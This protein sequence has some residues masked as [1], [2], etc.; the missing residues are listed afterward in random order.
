VSNLLR[1]GQA[2]VNDSRSTTVSPVAS[3]QMR[4][5]GM[6][7]EQPDSSSQ[8]AAVRLLQL[9]GESVEMLHS[10][11]GVFSDTI[12]RAELWL[13]RLRTVKMSSAGN[14]DM[15]LPALKADEDYSNISLPSLHSVTENQ[16]HHRPGFINMPAHDTDMDY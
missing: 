2:L 6:E 5:Y 1:D 10:V 12:D 9:G 11:S 7:T 4:P 8:E 15:K 14:E 13:D 3:P 16:L